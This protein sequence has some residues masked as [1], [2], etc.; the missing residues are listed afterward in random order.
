MKFTAD[1]ISTFLAF[2]LCLVI[3]PMSTVL[4]NSGVDGFIGRTSVFSVCSNTT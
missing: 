2:V 3:F 1:V 4:N